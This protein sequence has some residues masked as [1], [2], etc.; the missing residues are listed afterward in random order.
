MIPYTYCP[1]CA[2]KL[3]QAMRGGRPRQ[4]CPACDFI[5]YR[6]PTVGV[7]VIVLQDDKILMGRRAAG[8]SYA[9]KWCIPCGHV[10]WDEDVRTAAAREFEEETGLTVELADEIVAAH[11]NFHNAAQH[12]VGIWFRGH[13]TAGTLQAADDLDQI[14]YFPLHAP[15]QPLAFPTDQLVL[16]QLSKLSNLTL[17]H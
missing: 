14:D 13:V 16:A 1:Q 5:H 2:T 4:L 12:T 11:S 3:E 9:G 7:A 6:N 10:E 15:P 8:H 17:S